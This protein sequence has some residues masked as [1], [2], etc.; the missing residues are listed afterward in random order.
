V[1]VAADADSSVAAHNGD[2]VVEV[3]GFPH[4]MQRWA[5]WHVTY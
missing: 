2:V 5:L 1:V 3:A 4:D